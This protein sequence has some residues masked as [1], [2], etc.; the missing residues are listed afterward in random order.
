M[1]VP[2]VVILVGLLVFLAHALD[3]L[4][5]RTKVPDVLLLLVLGILLGPVSHL[6]SPGSF[7]QVGPVFTAITLVV[8]LFEG[9]LGL[10]LRQLLLSLRA[11]TLLCLLNFLA[12]VAVVAP[13]GHWGL[14][15]SWISSATLGAILG[16]TSSAVV[17]P[18]VRRIDLGENTRTAL[19]V[20]SA[21][22]DVL[23]IVVALGL[24]EAQR[25]GGLAV[26]RLLGSMG[27]SFALAGLLGVC[28]GVL[29]SLAL[30]R[31]H[32]LQNSI[33]TTPAFV[34][35]LYGLTELAGFSG[36]IAALATGITLGNVDRIPAAV[37]R[38]W[39]VSL[40]VLNATERGVFSELVF[41]LKTFFFVY[42]GLSLS[43]SGWW[44]PLVG[45]GITVALYAARVP[46]V[47][48]AVQDSV[49]RKEALVLAMMNPKGLAAAVVATLPAQMGLP[50]GEVIRDAAYTVVF[51]S[52]VLTS[53]LVFLQGRGWLDG[54]GA[55]LFKRFQDPGP[56]T[57]PE[58]PTP[59]SAPETRSR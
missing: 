22:S 11:S 59:D 15:L 27:A 24:L 23:V 31:V 46:V 1:N 49:P 16:G 33:L 43:V 40:E 44:T 57:P 29:W 20:E 25:G 4:F 19:T 52:V 38:R 28:G 42:I 6:V 58:A 21:L 8:I 17:I 5:V 30:N 7:G 54:L 13:L 51:C 56:G 34:L 10:D 37:N 14:G 39:F 41:L 9:G 35:V 3:D 12:S 48:L 45:L 2:A 26:G 50:G 18:L 36:A 55:W 32:G 47:R 53:G